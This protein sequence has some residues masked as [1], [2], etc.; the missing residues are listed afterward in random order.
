MSRL[1]IPEPCTC[2]ETHHDGANYYVSVVRDTA[3]G[4]HSDYRLLAG[5]FTDHAEALAWVDRAREL[6]L[7]RYNPDGRAHWYAYGTVAMAAGYTK[8]GMLNDQL[9]LD[10][11]AA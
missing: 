9:G 8:P 3:K 2:G 10:R 11:R 7:A 6:A 5:P 1:S 4:P